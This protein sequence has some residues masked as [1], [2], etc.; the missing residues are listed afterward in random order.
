[1][2]APEIDEDLVVEVLDNLDEEV[3][4]LTRDNL[5]GPVGLLASAADVIEQLAS[6]LGLDDIIERRR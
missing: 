1:M 2:S 3:D 4:R 5:L 6:A